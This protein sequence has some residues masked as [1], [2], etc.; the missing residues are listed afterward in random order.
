MPLAQLVGNP[1]V[2]ESLKLEK[3][4]DSE[5]GVGAF[6]LDDIRAELERPGR[7]PRP[8]FRV[9]EWRDDVTSVKDLEVGMSLEGRVSNVTNFG[10]FVDLGVKRDG[11]VHLSELSD[12]WVADPKTVVKVG[13]IV[14]VKV[15][16]VDR[17]RERISLS[18]KTGAA[19][20]RAP[21]LPGARG[22]SGQGQGQGPGRDPRRAAAAPGP[23]I[24]AASAGQAHAAGQG[25][26]LA[27]GPGEEVQQGPVSQ[28]GGWEPVSGPTILRGSRMSA[29]ASSDRRPRS[30]TSS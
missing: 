28:A 23:G 20:Q 8:I 13:Q 2:A 17:E 4:L 3:F 10:A 21:G 9:P 26:Q 7:D 14:R 30:S 15:L 12:E 19:P 16:E 29:R 11:L 22:P 1:A 6:T 25:S 5:K 24:A 18:M 27:V